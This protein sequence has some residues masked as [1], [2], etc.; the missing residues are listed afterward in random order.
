MPSWCGS[1][2]VRGLPS[3]TPPEAESARRRDQAA[4]SEGEPRNL[5]WHGPALYSMSDG[6]LLRWRGSRLFASEHGCR[7]ASDFVCGHVA[8]VLR[9]RPFVAEWIDDLPVPVAPEDVLEREEN[10]GARFHCALPQRLDVVGVD[11]KCAVLT[12]DRERREN[13]HLREFVG[14]HDR[15]VAPAKLDLHVPAVGDRNATALFSAEC[16]NVPVRGAGGVT[17]DDVRRDRM[18]NWGIR[19]SHSLLLRRPLSAP[20]GLDAANGS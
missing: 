13:P 2:V 15:R 6:P 5:L 8:D 20:H 12:A 18:F 4:F 17:H 10:L 11:R 1:S 19:V 14:D 3:R 7:S 16:L 9:E